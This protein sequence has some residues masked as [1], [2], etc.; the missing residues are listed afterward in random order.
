MN[1]GVPLF[2]DY[3]YIVANIFGIHKD[4]SILPTISPRFRNCK[5]KGRAQE[6]L[7]AAAKIGVILHKHVFKPALKKVAGSKMADVE[8]FGVSG[9][10]PLH[11][12]G[13]VGPVG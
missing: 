9:A 12:F 1:N 10:K 8:S 4:K 13:Q 7:K 5:S 11:D 6:P 2:Y 3:F